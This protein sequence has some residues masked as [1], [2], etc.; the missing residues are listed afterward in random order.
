MEAEIDQQL[1]GLSTYGFRSDG[2]DNSFQKLI[3]HTVLQEGSL[4]FHK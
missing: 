4:Y 2:G 1:H 3:Q